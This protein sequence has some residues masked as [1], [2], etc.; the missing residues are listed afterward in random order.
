M[1]DK[2]TVG[3]ISEQLKLELSDTSVESLSPLVDID[4]EV[5]VHALSKFKSK[6][7]KKCRIERHNLFLWCR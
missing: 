2:K 4:E 1:T 3:T 6:S 5:D 7:I